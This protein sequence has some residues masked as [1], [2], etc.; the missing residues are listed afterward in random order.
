M[1]RAQDRAGHLGY[2]LLFGGQ[3]LIANG[4]GAGWGI[5]LTGE[6]TWC[7]I[8]ARMGS[9]SIVLWGLVGMAIEAWGLWRAWQ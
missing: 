6:L 2:L 7:M 8:G 3:A 1:T 4:I 5:R 9:R